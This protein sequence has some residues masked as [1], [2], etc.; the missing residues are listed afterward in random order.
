MKLIP[1]ANVLILAITVG[2]AQTPPKPEATTTPGAKPEVAPDTVVLTVGTEK[3]TR[4]E[5]ERLLSTFSEQIRARA[6]GTGKKLL[7][8][9]LAELMA[10]AQEAKKRG[11]DK[12]PETQQQLA[13][14]KDQVLAG[15]LM[16]DLSNNVKP[17]EAAERAYYEQ[18]KG[19][20]ETVKASHILI[21]FKGSPVPVRKDQKDLTEEEALARA[22]DIRKKLVAGEDFAMLAKLN[23]DDTQS[24][25]NGGSLGPFTRGRMVPAFDQAAF[26]LPVGQVSEPIKTQFGYHLIK[27]DEHSTKPFEEARAEI[28]PKMKPEMARK[29]AEEIRKQTPITLNEAYFGK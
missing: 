25:A 26:S 1:I 20:Y 23:S 2:C 13:F 9:Q 10:M 3:M 7:A 17:D 28:T 29:A 24:G 8:D 16:K 22:Q 15:T 27:V 14:Q 12:K 11:I 4:A 21:R 6:Q 19:E 18:H 5:F